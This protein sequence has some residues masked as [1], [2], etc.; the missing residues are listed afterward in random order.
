MNP[1]LEHLL[2]KA[3]RIW[4]AGLVLPMNLAAELI[5]LGVDVEKLERECRA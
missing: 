4:S 2:E 3:D 5:A 1:H